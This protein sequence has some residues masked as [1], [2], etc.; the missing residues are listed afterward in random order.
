MAAP[1]SS[2]Y[3]DKLRQLGYEFRMNHTRIIEVNGKPITD[4]LA[5]EIRMAMRD[6]GFSYVKVME[7]AYTAHAYA[8]QY[9]PVHEYLESLS[10]SGQP[11]IKEL[12]S[13]FNDRSDAMFP[14]LRRWLI[15]SIAKAMESGQNFMLVLDGPQ[16]I[17]KS[18]FAKWICPLPDLFIEGGINT[19]EKDVWLRLSHYWVW[20]VDEL[21]ATT[22]KAD[23][24]ALKSFIT[25]REVTE[26]RS[27]GRYD[28][29]LPALASLIGTINTGGSGFLHDPTGNRRFAV[30]E[31]ESIDFDYSKNVDKHQVWAEAYQLYLGGE[32]WRLAE[33]E[34]ALQRE[35]NEEY[36]YS[37]PTEEFFWRYFD[38]DPAGTDWM[39]IADIISELEMRGLKTPQHRAMM[40]LAD[41]LKNAG[42]EKARKGRDRV[43]SYRGIKEKIKMGGLVP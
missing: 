37:S 23:R 31:L 1:K 30:V 24:S 16:D 15:G 42:V 14:F 4:G 22:R 41:L 10:W 27:Y 29:T 28:E 8:N 35:I 2:Q 36:E 7:D 12:A 11:A 32:D 13:Y 21:D 17:G 5:A 34:K 20:E 9:H 39:P 6:A 43:T 25:R 38:I 3:I 19:T 40:D 33:E 18:F 26:R